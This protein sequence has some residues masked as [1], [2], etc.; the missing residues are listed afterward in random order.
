MQ[1]QLQTTETLDS[2]CQPVQIYS[3][4]WST[5]ECFLVKLLEG[6][7]DWEVPTTTMNVHAMLHW[8]NQIHKWR[9][10]VMHT[11]AWMGQLNGVFPLTCVYRERAQEEYNRQNQLGHYTL[12]RLCTLAW[13]Q[14][15]QWSD[16][17]S[18]TARRSWRWDIPVVLPSK[19]SSLDLIIHTHVVRVWHSAGHTRKEQSCVT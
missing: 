8:H 6:V 2:C 10:A 9:I 5:S 15:T 11:L 16:V 1:E 19:Q 3:W 12:K 7:T 18:D 14:N 17:Y 13:I 4:R